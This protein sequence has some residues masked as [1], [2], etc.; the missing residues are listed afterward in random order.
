MEQKDNNKIIEV[1]VAYDE[2]IKN[3]FPQTHPL[4]IDT[5]TRYIVTDCPPSY[6]EHLKDIGISFE[7]PKTVT[8]KFYPKENMIKGEMKHINDISG[9][10]IIIRPKGIGITE[11]VFDWDGKVEI[12]RVFSSIDVMTAKYIKIGDKKLDFVIGFSQPS[13]IH[14]FIFDCEFKRGDK[15]ELST[16]FKIEKVELFLKTE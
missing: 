3:P 14:D 8:I 16:N 7:L 4:Q 9:T 5:T 12:V 15:F 6:A 1:K 10:K 2:W 13:K 11:D